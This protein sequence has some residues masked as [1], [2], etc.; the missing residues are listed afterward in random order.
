MIKLSFFSQ[1]KL[2]YCLSNLFFVK[3]FLF[4]FTNEKQLLHRSAQKPPSEFL[5]E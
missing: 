1:C 2:E 3:G 5:D 4:L